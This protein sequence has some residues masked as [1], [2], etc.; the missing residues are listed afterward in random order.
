MPRAGAFVPFA[1][2]LVSRLI[3][4]GTARRKELLINFL[5]GNQVTDVEM[6]RKIAAYLS[7]EKYGHGFFYTCT[8]LG[9]QLAVLDRYGFL[10]KYAEH[11]LGKPYPKV[12]YDDYREP[13][14]VLQHSALV[15][16]EGFS[17]WLELNILRRLSPDVHAI[18]PEREEFMRKATT[19]RDVARNSRYFKEFPPPH[20][21]PYEEARQ[22]LESVQQLY[23]EEYGFKC[24]VQAF[25]V[26]TAIPLGISNG[27]EAPHF[28]LA[29]EVLEKTLL[30]KEGGDARSDLRLWRI[31]RVL[32]DTKGGVCSVQERLQCHQACLHPECP[33]RAQIEEKLGWRASDDH[34]T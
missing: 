25:L 27:R 31:S 20:D 6:H 26:A 24:A 15:A 30:D 13:I 10:D 7:H 33:V 34:S 1:P 12:L 8:E 16:N 32:E 9:Q 11:I 22:L 18:I 28:A 17:A 5:K 23:S 14:K 19:L 29:A 3:K 21:S 2:D 4:T